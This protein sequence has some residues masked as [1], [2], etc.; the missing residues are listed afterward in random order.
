[1]SPKSFIPI[2]HPAP[3]FCNRSAAATFRAA[4]CRS[5]SHHKQK[6]HIYK[7][8]NHHCCSCPGLWEVPN[9][10]AVKVRQYLQHSPTH[11]FTNFTMLIL[12]D[13]VRMLSHVEPRMSAVSCDPIQWWIQWS[14]G[15]LIWPAPGGLKLQDSLMKRTWSTSLKA[16]RMLCSAHLKCIQRISNNSM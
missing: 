13:I 10:P 9:A 15:R 2:L 6:K 12:W 7:K 4:A 8:N 11:D 1:M 16:G 5:K 3:G 14:A